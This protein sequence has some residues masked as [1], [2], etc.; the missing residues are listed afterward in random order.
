MKTTEEKIK[1]TLRKLYKLTKAYYKE[2][3][4]DYMDNKEEIQ[5]YGAAC[6]G[7]HW[8]KNTEKMEIVCCL[9]VRTKNG[10]YKYKDIE[11]FA[12]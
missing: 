11:G 3:N 6:I 4:I 10:E 12:K 7:D 5:N 1:E 2:N 9:T 8:N